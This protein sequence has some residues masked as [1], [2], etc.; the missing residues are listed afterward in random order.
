MEKP[1]TD[2]ALMRRIQADDPDA[3]RN[4]WDVLVHRWTPRLHAFL[5]KRTGTFER[6]EEAM[7]DVWLRVYRSRAGFKPECTF[8]P[9]IFAITCNAGRDAWRP[10]PDI[11]QFTGSHHDQ[12]ELRTRLIHALHAMKAVDRRIVLLAAEGFTSLEIGEITGLSA[13]AAR[14]RLSRLR[15]TLKET[16]YA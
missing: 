4:A 10:D 11:F 7:Q 12:P 15:A 5:L 2:E 3:C 9:W 14:M 1:E 16:L 6:A 13:G 8:R